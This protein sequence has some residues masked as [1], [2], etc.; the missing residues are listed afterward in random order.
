M[1]S[2]LQAAVENA[3]YC[4]VVDSVRLFTGTV[5]VVVTATSRRVQGTTEPSIQAVT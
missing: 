4:W 1:P 5:D 2:P 3:T